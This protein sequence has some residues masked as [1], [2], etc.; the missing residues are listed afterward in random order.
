MKEK[1]LNTQESMSIITEMIERSKTRRMIGDGNILL[2]WGYLTVGVAALVWA[3]LVITHHPAVNWLW[4]LIWIIGGSATPILTRK[5][6]NQSGVTTYT[7][8]LCNALWSIVG[9]CAIAI[10]FISL[11]F[12]FIAGKD[13]WSA[14]LMYPLLIVGFAETIQGVIMREKSMVWGGAIGILAGL[15]TICCIAA[16]QV[17]HA[18][19]FMPMFIISFAMMMIIPGHVLNYKS[20]KEQ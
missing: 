10:T 1:E 12:L 20:R 19:W 9:Y 18:S 13:S 16:G 7:D 5:Q 14:F 15:F 17:L 11:G 6:R 8:K 3:L 2:L 4:F